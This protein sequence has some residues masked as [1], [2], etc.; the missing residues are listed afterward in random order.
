MFYNYNLMPPDQ[1]EHKLFTLL[2]LGH[3]HI[4]SGGQSEFTPTESMEQVTS[5]LRPQNVHVGFGLVSA[6]RMRH[7]MAVCSDTWC[8]NLSPRVVL[9]SLCAI[10]LCAR[11]IWVT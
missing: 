7:P 4:T 11:L 1:M 10:T 5:A 9:S 6:R 8:F 2:P 3:P